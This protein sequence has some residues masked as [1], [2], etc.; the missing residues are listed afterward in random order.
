MALATS[1][2]R[3]SNRFW[4]H[5]CGPFPSDACLLSGHCMRS[6]MGARVLQEIKRFMAL[7][8]GVE[9]LKGILEEATREWQYLRFLMNYEAGYIDVQQQEVWHAPVLSADIGA[10]AQVV[11]GPASTSAHR[12]ARPKADHPKDLAL[13]T[14][15]HWGYY[16]LSQ[17]FWDIPTSPPSPCSHRLRLSQR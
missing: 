14:T 9:H 15:G 17:L 13:D 8:T 16:T 6:G 2:N 7:S 1:S 10:P 12:R 11:V 3:L 4:G 5:L